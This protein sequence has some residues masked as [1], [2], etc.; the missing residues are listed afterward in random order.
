M[1]SAV[2]PNKG[3]IERRLAEV[4][5]QLDETWKRQAACRGHPRPDIFYPDPA[6][7][8]ATIKRSKS[9][10]KRRLIVAEAKRV[11]AAC[12]VRVECLNYADE[13]LDYHGIWGGKTG[14]ERGRKRD[15]F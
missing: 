13:I 8:E 12:P 15:E 14:R 3:R 10:L 1:A 9:E 5:G 11:C 4:S 6:R 7:S 2:F